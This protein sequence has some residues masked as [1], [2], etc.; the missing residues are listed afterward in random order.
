LELKLPHT[1]SSACP[2]GGQQNIVQKLNSTHQQPLFDRGGSLALLVSVVTLF[3]DD[4]PERGEEE[5]LFVSS[6]GAK[7]GKRAC[8]PFD[9]PAR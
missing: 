2:S 3:N 1:S 8:C 9:E 7:A 6:L 4:G 5:E